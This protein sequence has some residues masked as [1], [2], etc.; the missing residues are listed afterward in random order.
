MTIRALPYPQD[1]VADAM[2]L[3]LRQPTMEQVLAE[4][5]CTCGHPISLTHPVGH[6]YSNDVCEKNRR[7][8]LAFKLGIRSEIYESERMPAHPNCRCVLYP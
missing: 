3:R 1:R 8:Q 2:Q 7:Y 6:D 4:T 5:P